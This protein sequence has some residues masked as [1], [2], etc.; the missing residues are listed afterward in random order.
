[1][2]KGRYNGLYNEDLNAQFYIRCVTDGVKLFFF[3]LSIP[4]PYNL[5]EK[6]K[7]PVCG[8][9]FKRIARCYSTMA[10]NNY[11]TNQAINSSID[12]GFITGLFDADSSF[13]GG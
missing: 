9:R 2:N 3:I 10:N 8:A 6:R 13:V 11:T 12:P 5:F 4:W 7:P 1:M